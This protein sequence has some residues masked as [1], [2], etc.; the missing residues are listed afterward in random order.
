MLETTH[1]KKIAVGRTPHSSRLDGVLPWAY[2]PRTPCGLASSIVRR[3]RLLSRG[4]RDRRRR[5]WPDIVGMPC[6]L[7]DGR[8]PRKKLSGVRD[9]DREEAGGDKPRVRLWDSSTSRSKPSLAKG[10]RHYRRQKEL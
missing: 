9:A 2:E 7:F 10:P 1:S 3:R 8:I 6:H 5:D 4:S